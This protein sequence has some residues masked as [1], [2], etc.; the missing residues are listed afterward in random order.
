MAEEFVIRIQADDAATATIKKIQT[1]LGKVTAP[2]DKAQKRFAN[3]GAVG[4]RSFEKLT[5]GLESAARAAHTLVDKVVELVP[6]LA[7]LGAAGT[8]AG[9]VGL[10]NRFG[11]FGF[12]LNKS[13]KLLGMNAQDLAAWHVAAKRAGVSAEEFDSA[14]S[15]SQMAIRDAANGANPA[16]LVLMQKMGVQIQR[17]KDGTVDYYTTQ[18]KLMKAIAGQRNAVTQR[19]A[20]DA[21]GMGGLLPMLQQGT[22]NEDKARAFRKGLIPT[23]EE[24]ARATQFKEEI[25]DLEDS[26]SGL[27]NSIGASLIP[28]LEPVVKQF[29]VWLDNHRAEIADKLAAAVQRFVD[30]ISKVDWDGVSKSVKKMWDGMGGIKGAMIAIA[31]L[32]FAGPI[33]SVASLISSL[34][35]LTTVTVPAAAGALAGLAS[36]PVM[37][38]ILALLH[39][40]NLNEGEDEEV[41]K[42]QAKA[43]QA[44]DG[45]PVGKQH[46]AVAEAA[47][48]DPKTS[49]AMASLQAMGW[50]KAQAAGMVAN[51]WIESKLNPGVVGDNGEAYGIGQ[52]HADRQADFKAWSG[53]DIRGSTMEEQLRFVNHEL[54]NG[55]FW[56]AGQRLHGA[57]NAEDAGRLVSKFYERPRNVELEMDKRGSLANALAGVMPPEVGAPEANGAS[58]EGATADAHDARVRGMQQQSMNITLDM[59][60][61]PQGMR[62]EAKTADGNYLP[63]RVEYR[64]DGIM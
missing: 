38:A 3:I 49:A 13:S 63:T 31:A 37:A 32:S 50:S 30:W 8:V 36:A 58:G 18:Q 61:V 12:A 35:T 6:G 34:V 46:R 20:A 54:R 21:V 47:T 56:S 1:A 59:K 2:I 25:N 41:A 45:D 5:K 9:I 15:S 55:K 28:V 27:G 24:L 53:H 19:A 60:N 44:W 17:N 40:K 23:P 51:L 39:S 14:I 42:H 4:T 64:L 52:W 43:G 11:N 10:T 7:A 33:A 16:A 57:T 62:A 29:S 26:V 48:K 22:Y